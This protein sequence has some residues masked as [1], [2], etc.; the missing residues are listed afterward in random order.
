MNK[1]TVIH[2]CGHEAVHGY[3]GRDAELRQREEWLAR[4]PCQ[5]CWRAQRAGDA[6]AQTQGWNLPPLQ[7]GNEEIA[8]AE[9]IRVKA[10]AHNREFLERMTK[11]SQT[12]SGEDELCN[13]IAEASRKAMD[14]LEN[15]AD[16]AW[17]IDNRFGVLSYVH[18]ATVAAA[19]PL[20]PPDLSET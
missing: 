4:Q 8:W 14:E 20:L 16:A 6:L 5:V 7:G 9:V 1:F 11:L 13:V 19:A 18:Q 17:W 10:I 15:A 2:T 12:E 3:S